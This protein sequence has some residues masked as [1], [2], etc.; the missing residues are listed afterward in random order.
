MDLSQRKKEARKK[1]IRDIANF[2]SED[3]MEGF[4]LNLEKIL[5]SE[6]IFIHYDHYEDYFDGLLI[7][8]ASDFYIHLDIDSGNSKSSRRSRFSISH[9]LGHYYIPEHHKAIINGTFPS[10]PSK[11]RPKQRNYLEEEADIFAAC[12]LMPS[13]YFKKACLKRKFSFDLIDKLA[14]GFNVSRLSTLLRFA[15][16]DAGTF[17]LMISFYRRG[18]LTGFKQSEDFPLKDVPFRSKIGKPPP[19]TSVIGEYY[20]NKEKRFRDV[21]EVYVNDWFWYDSTQKLNEQ[22]FYSNYDY[23]ISVIWPD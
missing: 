9:E 19:P 13:L 8:E 3:Y 4:K 23:D 17:P 5:R 14:S 1:K 10:H 18:L 11:F 2:I 6:S 12:L 15:D 21:Q 20:L 7:Y 16:K 22:C